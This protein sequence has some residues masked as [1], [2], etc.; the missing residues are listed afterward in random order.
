MIEPPRVAVSIK[1]NSV[2]NTYSQDLAHG[3]LLKIGSNI[4]TPSILEN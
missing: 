3:K 4:I 1:R 2:F